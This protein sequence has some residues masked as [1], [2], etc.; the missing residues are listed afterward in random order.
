[1]SCI[2][3]LDNNNCPICRISKSTIPKSPIVKN[4]VKIENLR[5]EN[6]FFKNHIENKKQSE[7][8]LTQKNTFLSPNLIN[9]LPVPNLI[10]SI[11]NFENKDFM[12]KLDKL[13]I[14]GL[15]T[16]GISKKINLESPTVKL[17]EE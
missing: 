6:P 2:H 3:G 16:H 11:P 12:K 4:S 10:N 1:M 5:P 7:E 14:N 9:P 15:D 13:D 8:Y 17:D